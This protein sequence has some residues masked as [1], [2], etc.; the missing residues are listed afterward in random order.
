MRNY[1]YICKIKYTIWKVCTACILH[2]YN[3]THMPPVPSFP[4]WTALW[5][6]SAVPFPFP[7]PTSP[8]PFLIASPSFPSFPSFLCLDLLWA[9]SL[10]SSFSC[11]HRKPNS[12]TQQWRYN[13]MYQYYNNIYIY[14]LL[15]M[16]L[17]SSGWGLCLWLF[18]LVLIPPVSCTVWWMNLHAFSSLSSLSSSLLSL[19]SPDALLCFLR[20]LPFLRS[21]ESF[22]RLPLHDSSK[23]ESSSTAAKRSSTTVSV[24]SLNPSESHTRN[25]RNNCAGTGKLHMWRLNQ[26]FKFIQICQV[27]KC[28]RET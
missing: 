15:V 12:Q 13:N 23:S 2:K 26:I 20:L 10:L 24:V 28:K 11:P 22:L 8:V 17:K 21:P 1:I 5:L 6:P 14:I 9:S 19:H 7:C 4:Y 3:E 16:I 27:V 18:D 25:C